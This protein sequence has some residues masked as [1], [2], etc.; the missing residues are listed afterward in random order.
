MSDIWVLSLEHVVDEINFC[1]VV[2]K[3]FGWMTG[4]SLLH[5]VLN[6]ILG[7]AIVLLDDIGMDPFTVILTVNT[8][9]SLSKKAQIL[10]RPSTNIETNKQAPKTNLWTHVMCVMTRD[11]VRVP[12]LNEFVTISIN[13]VEKE[14]LDEPDVAGA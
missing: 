7:C 13:I 6:V 11:W 12:F 10:C 4:T 5:T 1:I 14:G 9:L 8:Q 3:F 2:V